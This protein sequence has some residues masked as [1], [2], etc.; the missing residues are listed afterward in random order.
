MI[1]CYIWP[2]IGD[3]FRPCRR[4]AWPT[5]ILSYSGR[6][7]SMLGLAVLH[8]SHQPSYYMVN[9]TYPT[10]DRHDETCLTDPPCDHAYSV[11]CDILAI[12][13]TDRDS[14]SKDDVSAVR[15]QSWLANL[16][17][18]LFWRGL[19]NRAYLIIT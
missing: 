15:T 16:A 13:S 1:G 3:R 9:T 12:Q 6:L 2:P 14:L 17:F 18:N 10:G 19:L 11:C 8:T 5:T 4:C 7:A